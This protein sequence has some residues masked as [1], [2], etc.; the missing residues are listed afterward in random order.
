MTSGKEGEVGSVRSVGSEILV[1][2]TELSYT[3]TQPARDGRPYNLYHGTLEARPVTA[4]TSK[5]VY[6][7]MFDNSMLADDAARKADLERR[8]TT[9][10]RAMNNMKTLAEGKLDENARVGKLLP[11]LAGSAWAD[12]TVRQVMDMTDGV[13]FN[14]N[15]TDPKSDIFAYVGAMG[16]APQYNNPTNPSGILAMLPTLKSLHDEPRGTAFRYRSPATDV[17]AWI[18]ARTANQSVSAWLQQRLWS[19]LG[20][21]YDGSFM[22][23]PLGT[24]VSFAGMS[25]S[26]HDLARVGQMLLQHGR[27]G[28]QQ[29]IPA[30]VVDELIRGGDPR[31]FE[32]AGM[33]ERPGWS[34]RA[35]WW[36]N[37]QPPRSFAAMGAFGQRLYVFPD[38]DTVIVMFGSH[39]KPRPFRRAIF[40]EWKSF[41][42]IVDPGSMPRTASVDL[43]TRLIALASPCNPTGRVWPASELRALCEGLVA[44]P[45]A[46]P[47]IRVRLRAQAETEGIAALH[48]QLAEIDEASAARISKADYVRIERALEVYELTGK[49]MTD[50][51]REN[52]AERAQGPRYQTIR[53]GLDPGPETLRER[54]AVR[55][56]SWLQDG[57]CEE[58]ASHHAQHGPMQFPPLGYQQVLRHL[59]GTGSDHLDQESMLREICQKTAQY[60]RRQRIWFRSEPG[61]AWYEDGVQVDSTHLDAGSI[62]IPPS[63]E[64]PYVM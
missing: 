3:Y 8:R 21:E 24:E 59:Y 38:H 61:I 20:M 19:R 12:A 6:T 60:A 17:T 44:T 33:P 11:E 39:P 5:I 35:Q 42:S 27:V 55:T 29:I 23:D 47:E 56:Q 64:V 34:Y 50:W 25:A 10:T 62:S 58:V 15:Y 9:F 7:L 54:I 14:E 52:Q 18:A 40:F 26:V 4:N 41:S 32:A 51:H 22:L 30:S 57:L 43:Y 46:D 53:I 36:V 16:W 13:R 63:E 31:A 45:K 49:T 37:P 48:A 28:E 2:K 1:G